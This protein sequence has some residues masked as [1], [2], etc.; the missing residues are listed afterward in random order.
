MSDAIKAFMIYAEAFEKGFAADDWRLVDCLFDKSI[1]WTLAGPP[2][3]MAYSARGNEAVSAGIKKSVD[4]FDRRFDLRA[5]AILEGPVAIPGG[6]YIQGRVTYTRDG[7]P[8]FDLLGEEWDL[9]REGKMTMHH[10]LIH[11]PGELRKFISQH[12]R[13]LLPAR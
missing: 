3:P 6:V 5:P 1:V 4:S 12:D 13:A 10:E 9:F 2:P 11:N 8:P 7:L